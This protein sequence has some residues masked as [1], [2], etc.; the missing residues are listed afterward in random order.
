MAATEWAHPHG[1]P[2]TQHTAVQPFDRALPGRPGEA[3][4]ISFAEEAQGFSSETPPL[5]AGALSG[6]HVFIFF[7]S[8]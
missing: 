3:H 8:D 1:L 5:T 6:D 2:H 4:G 7:V